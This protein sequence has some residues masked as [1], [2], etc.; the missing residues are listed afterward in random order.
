MTKE[1][2]ERHHDIASPSLL[3]LWCALPLQGWCQDDAELLLNNSAV[4]PQAGII[5]RLW[6]SQLVLV[7][8][9]CCNGGQKEERGA[10]EDQ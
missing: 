7:D 8:L 2:C 9:E 10:V 3:E 4:V 6:F 5:V 1:D